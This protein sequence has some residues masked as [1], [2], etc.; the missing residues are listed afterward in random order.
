VPVREERVLGHQIIAEG[1]RPGPDKV[2]AVKEF[3]QLPTSGK[4]ADLVKWVKSFLGLVSYYR[5]FL[6]GFAEVANPLMDLTKDKTLFIW[7]ASH[8]KSFDEIKERLA[9]AAVLTYPDYSLNFEIHPD[10]C[11][12]GVVAVLVQR[13]MGEER[14]LAFASRT[15]TASERNYSITE[16]E[17]LAL[18]WSVKRFRFF[19]W[20]RPIR[21]VTDHN[22]LCWLQSWKDLAGRPS[23]WAMQLM[24]YKYIIANKDG[25]LH[26]DAN[27]LSRYPLAERSGSD[28]T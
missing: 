2:R 17:C 21:I 4:R 22:A 23:R 8:Q 14:P 9:K 6:L 5:R 27:A 10:A 26:A 12:Y 15:M 1:V 3:P 24:E 20:G 11:G 7:V 18:V 13:Q 16:K 28:V 25:R 19:I